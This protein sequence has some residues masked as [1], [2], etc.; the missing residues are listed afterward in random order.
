MAPD[1][2]NSVRVKLDMVRQR[3][4]PDAFACAFVKGLVILLS[5]IDPT[6]CRSNHNY[7]HIGQG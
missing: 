3:T 2:S 7:I 4:A 5:H 6:I 1:F